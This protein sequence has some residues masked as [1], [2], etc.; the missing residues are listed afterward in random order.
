MLIADLVHYVRPELPSVLDE[1]IAQEMAATAMDFCR[2]TLVWQEIQE[3]VALMDG[4]SQ[5]DMEGP[6]DA[7]VLTI[8]NVWAAERELVAVTMNHLIQVL[9]NWQTAQSSQPVYY[10]A[11]RDL[12][13]I[14]VYPTPMGAQRAQLT[15]KAQYTPKRTAKTLPDFLG[16]K[17]HDALVS[18]TKA[19]MMLK[20]NVFWSNPNA[21][22]MHQQ[23]YEQAVA[24][25]QIDQLHEQVPVSIRVRPVRF[26]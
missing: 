21:G 11:A 4:V 16:E 10:N 18:G 2:R 26:G 24:K 3:P 15:F 5:Y 6:S 13:A 7:L 20:V 1:I 25:A 8:L 12:N 23:D 22:L 17:Y 14:T 9:P 19:R